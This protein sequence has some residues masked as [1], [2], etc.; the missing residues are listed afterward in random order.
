MPDS[1]AG[2]GPTGPGWVRVAAAGDVPPGELMAV[3][4]NNEQVVLANVDDEIFALEDRCSHQDF[5]LSS[6][7]LLGCEV[8]CAYHG[9][10]FDLRTGR[11]TRLPALRPV[12][13]FPVGVVDGEVYL[14]LR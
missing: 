4:A 11:A 14:R 2:S 12:R 9:A 5:P 10:T 6:G 3:T 1:D 8:E 7:E 13:T